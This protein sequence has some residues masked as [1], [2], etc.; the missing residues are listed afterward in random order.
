MIFRKTCCVI[1]IVGLTGASVASCT[2]V[3][4]QTGLGQKTQIGAAGGAA[5]GGL[6]AAAV[7]ASPLGLA[8][9]VI[10]GGLG[11][12][13]IGSLLDDND[14]DEALKA[15]QQSLEKNKAGQ[16]TTWNDPKDGDTGTY[17][18]HNTYTTKDGLTCRDYEQTVT[19][20]G[21][22][23]KATGTACKTADGSWRVH[24]PA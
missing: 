16:T 1:A 23:E 24:N 9:G 18:P 6:L 2:W 14:K 19:I 15:Q 11:G 13:A 4:E 12:G 10:L 20:D 5:A 21:K 17:T 7:G 8:A 3:E 22:T